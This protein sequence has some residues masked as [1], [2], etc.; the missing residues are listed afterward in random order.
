MTEAVAPFHERFSQAMK[1]LLDKLLEKNSK[2]VLSPG[3]VLD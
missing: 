1:V 2:Y 3:Y